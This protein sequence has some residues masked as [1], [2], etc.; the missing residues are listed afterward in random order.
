MMQASNPFFPQDICLE[1]RIVSADHDRMRASVER[2]M[3]SRG[4]GGRGRRARQGEA[5]FSL[6][7]ET[8]GRLS[9]FLRASGEDA[10]RT[11]ARHGSDLV[12]ALAGM[13]DEVALT[14]VRHQPVRLAA[15][16]GG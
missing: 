6:R 13:Q 3:Q 8:E 1:A 10:P 7:A 12:R 14:W 16:S 11:L 2:W 5:A 4:P 15:V 9:V